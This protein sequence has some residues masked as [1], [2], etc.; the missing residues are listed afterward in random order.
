MGSNVVRHRDATRRVALIAGVLFITA[1]A[2]SLVGTTLSQ[3]YLTRPDYLAMLSAHG[4]RVSAGALFEF[5]AAATSVS[6]AICLYPVLSRWNLGIALGS[7][8]FR[9]MEAVLYVAGLVSLMS[10][11]ALGQQ[12]TKA[13]AVERGSLQSIGDS[14][15]T[16]RNEAIVAGVLA[17]SLGA[18]MYYYLFYV[19]RLI[20]RWLSGWGIAAIILMIVA[21]LLGWFSHNPVSSYTILALPIGVQE[22]VLAV[23]LIAK[24]FNP[25]ALQSGTGARLP[26]AVAS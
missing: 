2:A 23:W 1:T 24:G 5:L 11:T 22:L 6:I 12:F 25:R 18:L 21:C 9:A 14:L 8:V 4:N 17:F 10:V 3:P 16:L 15:L 26:T 19:S 20:P 13:G 7:V